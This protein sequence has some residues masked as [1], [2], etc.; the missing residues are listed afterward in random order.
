MKLSSGVMILSKH[1]EVFEKCDFN[2]SKKSDK[3]AQKSCVLMQVQIGS[4]TLLIGGTHLDSKS[5]IRYLQYEMTKV[6][7]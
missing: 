7:S 6:K 1:P 4:K 3:A 2:T 5:R